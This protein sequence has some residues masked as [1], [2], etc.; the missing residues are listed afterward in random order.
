VQRAL[1]ALK[2]LMSDGLSYRNYREALRLAGVGETPTI[3][4]LGAAGWFQRD[5]L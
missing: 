1:D 2:Q 3:P 5:G 4:F